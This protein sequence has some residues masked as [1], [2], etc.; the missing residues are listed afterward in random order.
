MIKLIPTKQQWLR[1][2]LPSKL[3]AIGTAAG[4]FSIL[5]FF[6]DKAFQ[7]INDNEESA[8]FEMHQEES[9]ELEKQLQSYKNGENALLKIFSSVN[10][11]IT[12]KDAALSVL[13]NKI[14]DKKAIQHLEKN[15]SDISLETLK[16]IISLYIYSE[17]LSGTKKHYIEAMIKDSLIMSDYIEKNIDVEKMRKEL[18]N[19]T[20]KITAGDRQNELL[21]R[22]K[23]M[24]DDEVKH[25][26]SQYVSERLLKKEMDDYMRI[27]DVIHYRLLID[28]E[29]DQDKKKLILNSIGNQWVKDEVIN[30][31]NVKASLDKTNS[32]DDIP[33]CSKIDNINIYDDDT[34]LINRLKFISCYSKDKKQIRYDVKIDS[35]ND[36]VTK[37][38]VEESYLCY[39]KYIEEGRQFLIPLIQSSPSINADEKVWWM[40]KLNK[41]SL[42]PDQLGRFTNMLISERVNIEKPK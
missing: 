14:K 22:L 10:Q 35:F 5:L 1:W 36:C 24:R 25:H 8:I 16:K 12:G 7:S 27:I 9:K 37:I 42:T 28:E 31:K 39:Q 33:H 21:E 32:L 41:N 40:K 30:Y 15:K 23:L 13:R 26:Y 34:T 17:S 3:T 2:S 29:N 6:I 11:T 38:F 4:V 19:L 20:K 18:K